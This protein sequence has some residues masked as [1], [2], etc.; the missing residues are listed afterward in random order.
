MRGQHET[1]DSWLAFESNNASTSLTKYF[2][3]LHQLAGKG[4]KH[5]DEKSG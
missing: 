5:A 4:G 1:L 2:S 3:R